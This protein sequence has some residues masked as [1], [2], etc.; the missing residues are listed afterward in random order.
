MESVIVAGADSSVIG[1][2]RET[3]GTGFRVRGI[4]KSEKALLASL[5]GSKYHY[6]FVDLA[7]LKEAAS[8][9]AASY[10]SVLERLRTEGDSS[11]IIV[12]SPKEMAGEAVMAVRAGA[13]DYLTYPL[14][15]IE[16]QHVLENIK[17]QISLESELDYLRDRFWQTE[18]LEN[19]RTK[20]EKMRKVFGMIRS[21][22]P[23]KSTVLLFGETGT[24]KGLLARI[25]HTH[26]NRRDN[27]FISVHCGAIPETLLES[28]LFGH[29]K[30]AFT[31]AIRKKL[32]KFEMAD[33]GTIFLDEVSTLTAAAQIKM[34]QVLQDGTF[35]RVGG[36]ETIRVD[37]RVISATNVPLEEMC[38][39]G[40][41]RKDLYYRLNVFP[42]EIP[43]LSARAEDIPQLAMLFLRKLETKGQKGILSIGEKVMEGLKAYPWPGNIRE[44]ENL[45]ERA[46]I[47]GKAPA[48]REDD[49]PDEI[50][51]FGDSP[52]ILP[53]DASKTLAEMRRRVLEEAEKAY[54]KELL[55]N[56]AGKLKPAAQVAGITTRQLHK[57]MKKH[58]LR[59][60]DFKASTPSAKREPAVHA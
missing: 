7:I 26:S 32:G 4:N 59:K 38:R 6:L 54:L 34:L 43:S 12:L 23:T 17:D 31:G 22:A 25:I 41:F 49:F 51:S 14:D 10:A 56:S 30:G 19:I 39:E 29:E 40:E 24:G 44:L 47:L 48:L 36:E 11:R 55:A 46:Y 28:E 18:S 9:P 21:V 33:G 3:M 27:Q 15:P 2:I 60:E 20:N 16:I 13:S 37:V 5:A 35:Q 42:I 58:S 50:S 8:E 57:L 1:K 45:M 53:I 52:S